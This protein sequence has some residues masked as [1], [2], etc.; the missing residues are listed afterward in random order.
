MD[1]TLDKGADVGTIRNRT[2]TEEEAA[3]KRT[4]EKL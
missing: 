3:K 2:W 1:S 4:P